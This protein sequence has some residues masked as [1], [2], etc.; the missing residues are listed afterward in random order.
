MWLDSG[1]GESDKG[2]LRRVFFAIITFT[3]ASGKKKKKDSKK[4]KKKLPCC[5]LQSKSLEDN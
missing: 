3:A 2:C 4:K 1:I 5:Q